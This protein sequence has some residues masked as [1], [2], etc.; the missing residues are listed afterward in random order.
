MPLTTA[1]IGNIWLA[2]TVD[3]VT[4]K[5]S[6]AIDLLKAAVVN[7]YQG[8]VAAEQAKAIAEAQARLGRALSLEDIA[9]IREEVGAEVAENL[10]EG[11][12]L[13]VTPKTD[14]A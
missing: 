12:E 1:D 13:T 14:P 4:G 8:R 5:P 6:K 2:A 10:S 7:S 3:P 11:Y 9:T